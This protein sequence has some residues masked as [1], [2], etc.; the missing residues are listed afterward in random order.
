[1]ARTR[2]GTATD[3]ASGSVGRAL[4]RRTR[5]NRKNA[6]KQGEVKEVRKQKDRLLP[7]LSHSPKPDHFRAGD[8]IHVSD[9]LYKCTRAISIAAKV[10]QPILP[11]IV[12]DAQGITFAQGHAI[13]DYVTQRLKVNAKD[14]LYGSWK[15]LCQKSVYQG[16]MSDAL[17]CVPCDACGSKLDQYHELVIRDD[18]LRLTGAI[19][20]ALLKSQYLYLGECKSMKK[21]DWDALRR[22]SP[23][24]VI[25]I[26]FYWL[27]MRR[28]GYSLMDQVSILYVP[29]Q[30]VRGSPYKEFTLQ[31]SANLD[32]LDPY[33]EEA[34]ELKGCLE[35]ATL[36]ARTTCGTE[37]APQ[38]KRC[39]FTIMCFAH[40][41]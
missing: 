29:K 10:N 30:Q 5:R 39:Q 2:R 4:G 37:D 36:C 28:A 25:Q 17:A 26:L 20:I 22:P 27:L 14:E 32:R 3:K 8:Y 21:D 24:H 41:G 16:V 13:Q 23:D 18:E 31:P 7:L 6:V 9:L 33:L 15:C 38:A 1:M 12:W 19:D 40:D 34:R 35:N 11:Q